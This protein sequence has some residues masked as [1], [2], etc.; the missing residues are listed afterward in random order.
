MYAMYAEP[1][2]IYHH[3]EIYPRHAGGTGVQ[4]VGAHP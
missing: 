2:C 1:P 3:E 4:P